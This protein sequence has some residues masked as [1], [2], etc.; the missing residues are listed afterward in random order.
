MAQR[1]EQGTP[2]ERQSVDESERRM[3][4]RM[5]SE[6]EGQSETQSAKQKWKRRRTES[7]SESVHH[8]GHCSDCTQRVCKRCRHGDTD[9]II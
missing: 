9:T 4:M 3:R 8:A 5:R 7:E 2:S 1:P 6:R